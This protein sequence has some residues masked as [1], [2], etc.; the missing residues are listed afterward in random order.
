[1][2]SLT[3]FEKKK[4]S[5]YRM[6]EP[7]NGQ[8]VLWF[9]SGQRDVGEYPNFPAVIVRKAFNSVELNVLRP[10]ATTLFLIGVRHADDPNV[11]DHD[12]ENGSWDFTDWDKALAR[13]VHAVE[14]GKLPKQV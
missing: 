13:V 5:S 3:V 2:S 10:D 4:L 9:P 8:T 11:R 12:L 14:S 6:P 7:C 1:M